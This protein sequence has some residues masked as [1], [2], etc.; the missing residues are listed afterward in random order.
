M[1][2]A[3]LKHTGQFQAGFTQADTFCDTSVDTFEELAVQSVVTV[4]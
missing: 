1:V 4:I 2:Q 3:L